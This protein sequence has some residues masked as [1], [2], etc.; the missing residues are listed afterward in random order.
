MRVTI[1][2]LYDDLKEYNRAKTKRW[3]ANNKDKVK[4]KDRK[5]RQTETYKNYMR[6]YLRK[7]RA[8]PETK[9]LIN[10]RKEYNQ[11]R[12]VMLSFNEWLMTTKQ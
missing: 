10:K 3:A 6:E 2:S 4:E 1:K 7:R 5:H 12:G 9:I 8:N 11:L